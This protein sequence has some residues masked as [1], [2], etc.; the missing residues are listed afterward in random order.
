MSPVPSILLL[1]QIDDA[2][3]SHIQRNGS[4]L[5]VLQ[6]M[7]CREKFGYKRLEFWKTWEK[8][9][10]IAITLRLTVRSHLSSRCLSINNK[11][12]A[13]FVYK[14]C[15]VQKHLVP[16]V[17]ILCFERLLSDLRRSRHRQCLELSRVEWMLDEPS[18]SGVWLR[19]MAGCR[20]HSTGNEW[21]WVKAW[22]SVL[23]LSSI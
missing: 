5:R 23:S 18:G 21:R 13:P 4:K 9:A 15:L 3:L 2:E 22:H 12:Q 19:R 20:C 11:R 10:T 8:L 14:H 1:N 17:L 7:I 16:N 6:R